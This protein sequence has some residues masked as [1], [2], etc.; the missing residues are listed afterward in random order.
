M[1]TA[2]EC[3]HIASIAQVIELM[4]QDPGANL[5]LTTLASAANMAQS[6]FSHVFRSVTCVSPARFVAALRIE[7]AKTLLLCS[8]APVGEICFDCGYQSIGTFTR[9]FTDF[10]GISPRAFRAL[11]DSLVGTCVADLYERFLQVPGSSRNGARLTGSISGPAD[12]RGGILVGVFPYAIPRGKPLTGILTPTLGRFGMNL[13]RIK[14]GTHLFA[15]AVPID[16]RPEELLLASS[17]AL[18]A[19]GALHPSL[20]HQEIDLC[21][22]KPAWFDPPILTAFSPVIVAPAQRRASPR[23]A[24]TAASDAHE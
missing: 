10:V 9:L 3:S 15:A 23:Y 12:F 4:R 21:L 16:S 14:R 13:P 5:Q 17:A 2:T 11:R 20:P 8:H 22:R 19:K 6:H 18:V 1:K 7:K 24:M